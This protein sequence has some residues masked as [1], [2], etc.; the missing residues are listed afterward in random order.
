MRQ[1]P[2]NLLAPWRQAS[3]TEMQKQCLHNSAGSD[4]RDASYYFKSSVG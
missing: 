3:L 2:E 4:V 1:V